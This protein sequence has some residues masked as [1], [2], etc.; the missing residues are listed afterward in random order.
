M[1]LVH[2]D[3]PAGLEIVRMPSDAV[4]YAQRLY[5]TLHTLDEAGCDVIFVERVPNGPEWLAA[6]DRLER[7][8]TP[9]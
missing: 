8:S 9:N 7:A 4:G 1:L 6:Q 3:D 5:A 2:L